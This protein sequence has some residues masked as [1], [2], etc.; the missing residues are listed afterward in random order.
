LIVAIAGLRQCSWLTATTYH[1]GCPDH[2]RTRLP[3]RAQKY[4]LAFDTH[5]LPQVGDSLAEILSREDVRKVMDTARVKRKRPV[6]ER[7]GA[8]GGI[9]AARTAVS[10]MRLYIPQPTKGSYIL[11]STGGSKPIKGIAKF[12]K[13]RLQAQIVE[14]MTVEVMSHFLD[15]L[16]ASS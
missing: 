7:G 10:V 13:T 11:S 15:E 4:E 12:F 8:I 6:G 9:E 3:G 2:P 1:T 14:A 5:I 16:E